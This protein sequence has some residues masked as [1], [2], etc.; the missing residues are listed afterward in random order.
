MVLGIAPAKVAKTGQ[1][2]CYD[3]LGVEI[4][5]LDTGQDGEYQKGVIGPSPRF[6][7]HGDGTVTDN[8]N[9]INVDSGCSAGFRNDDMVRCVD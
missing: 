8:L 2:T 6:T 7:D 3:E 1:N 5:C 9:W 4:N